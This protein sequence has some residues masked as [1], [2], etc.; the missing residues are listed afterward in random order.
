MVSY[1]SSV[2]FWIHFLTLLTLP[3]ARP[4]KSRANVGNLMLKR[5]KMQIIAPI[6]RFR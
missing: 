4:S 3:I 6:V 5:G 1:T 2:I